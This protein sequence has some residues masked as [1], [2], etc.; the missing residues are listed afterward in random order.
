MKNFSFSAKI[1]QDSCNFWYSI[2]KN[3]SYLGFWYKIEKFFA[4]DWHL[5]CKYYS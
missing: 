5:Y 4:K 1:Y 2:Y 3:I